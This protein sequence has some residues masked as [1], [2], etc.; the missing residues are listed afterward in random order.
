M[1][2]LSGRRKGHWQVLANA[3]LSRFLCP[4]RGTLQYGQPR[5]DTG[6][7]FLERSFEEADLRA[8]LK[9]GGSILGAFIVARDGQFVLYMRGSWVKNRAYRIIRTWRGKEGDRVFRS[10]D[11]AYRFL[12]RFGFT[13]RVMVYPMRD[14]ELRQFKGVLST[15]LG[16]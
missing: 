5:V 12:R 14:G 10:L 6:A 16:D 3:C 8:G 13:G 1:L 11:V 15:D 9:E 4:A 2:R 7:E